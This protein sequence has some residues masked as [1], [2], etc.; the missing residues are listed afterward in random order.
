MQ[1]NEDDILYDA[2]EAFRELSNNPADSSA[3][4]KWEDA[5][6]ELLENTNFTEYQVYVQAAVSPTAP[7]NPKSKNEYESLAKKLKPAAAAASAINY[8]LIRNGVDEFR[9]FAK[10]DK[11]NTW[12]GIKTTLDPVEQEAV[13]ILAAATSDDPDAFISNAQIDA[14]IQQK[15]GGIQRENKKIKTE[16]DIVKDWTADLKQLLQ[17]A[18]KPFDEFVDLLSNSMLGVPEDTNKLRY[19]PL[20]SSDDVRMKKIFKEDGII[21]TMDDFS[22]H[23][24][25]YFGAKLLQFYVGS[26]ELPDEPRENDSG[27]SQEEEDNYDSFSGTRL[28]G[29]N[30]LDMIVVDNYNFQGGG[31][32]GG[33]INDSDDYYRNTLGWSRE[34]LELFR[35]QQRV[36]RKLT[37]KRG[38]ELEIVPSWVM[39]VVTDELL[40]QLCHPSGWAAMLHVAA[41]IARQKNCQ[42]YTLRMLING[43]QH[44]RAMFAMLCGIHVRIFGGN[45]MAQSTSIRVSRRSS[46]NNVYTNLDLAR[47]YYTNEANRVL[48]WFEL[49][50]RLTRNSELLDSF[51]RLRRQYVVDKL[52]S[53]RDAGRGEGNGTYDQWNLLTIRGGKPDPSSEAFKWNQQMDV[54]AA[55]LPKSKIVYW[56]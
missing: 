10:G 36:M 8:D 39:S 11:N 28:I 4:K 5:K 33:N 31:G 48:V 37:Q 32:G 50:T 14:V 17:V 24:L 15:L 55:D 51:A 45:V 42:S 41:D 25:R 47:Q 54:V 46:N 6:A 18:V 1:R 7:Y 22:E 34:K 3:L 23:A 9:K 43:D 30:L 20:R 12:A 38:I 49:R 52:K 2:V 44:V 13:Y 19:N 26:Y 27:V 53:L 16:A 29:R 40:S 21:T 56:E 35:S